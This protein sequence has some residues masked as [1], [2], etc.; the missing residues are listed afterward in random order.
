[1]VA[2]FIAWNYVITCHIVSRSLQ[3]FHLI[4]C[5]HSNRYYLIISVYCSEQ[6]TLF[7]SNDF[8]QY[9]YCLNFYSV[10]GYK[11]HQSTLVSNGKLIF[12]I[13]FLSVYVRLYTAASGL[14][15]IFRENKIY[16]IRRINRNH[17]DLV[18]HSSSSSGISVM[19]FYSIFHAEKKK[20][21][22]V[23]KYGK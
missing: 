16:L 6:Q 18:R 12:T 23:G 14:Q 9:R 21:C 1:M 17:N 13:I 20:T 22:A 4:C 7:H 15:V 8:P 3:C 11:I 2:Q 19:S 5:D 10:L